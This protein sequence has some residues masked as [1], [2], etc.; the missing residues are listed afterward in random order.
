MNKI[1]VLQSLKVLFFIPIIIKA[2]HIHSAI[3]LLLS[4]PKVTDFV[5]VTS[6]ILFIIITFYLSSIKRKEQYDA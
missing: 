1:K 2:C 4:Y 5:T 3:D 6:I